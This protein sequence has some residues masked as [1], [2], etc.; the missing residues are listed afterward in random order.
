M[1]SLKQ[2]RQCNLTR[3]N[4][5]EATGYAIDVKLNEVSKARFSLPEAVSLLR[6]LDIVLVE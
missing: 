5:E 1:N 4:F 2:F 6:S 3:A